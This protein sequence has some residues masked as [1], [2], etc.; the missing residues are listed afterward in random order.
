MCRRGLQF[1]CRSGA[2]NGA[3]GQYFVTIIAILLIFSDQCANATPTPTDQPT[4]GLREWFLVGSGIEG[5][6]AGDESGRTI[7][8]SSDGS[9][10][11]ISSYA[12]DGNGENA[13]HVRVF[14]FDS[15]TWVQLGAD[16][17]GEAAGD[18]SG[19]SVS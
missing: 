13:G 14:E 11:A 10:V 17:D 1:S 7:S 8:L 6:A 18:E 5:E 15:S 16:I 4:Y 12:N 19:Y 9:R 3:L 2:N